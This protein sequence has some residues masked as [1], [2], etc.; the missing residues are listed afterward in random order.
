MC[1]GHLWHLRLL[2]SSD[3]MNFGLYQPEFRG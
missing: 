3:I 2:T 1:D